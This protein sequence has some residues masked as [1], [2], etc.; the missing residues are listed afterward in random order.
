MIKFDLVKI[1]AC[2]AVLALAVLFLP[3]Q[4]VSAQNPSNWVNITYID[5]YDNYTARLSGANT[6]AIQLP[7]YDGWG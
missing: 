2:K 5:T 6:I 3:C 7:V 1:M 4:Y